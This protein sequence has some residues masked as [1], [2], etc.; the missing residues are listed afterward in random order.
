MF[1]MFTQCKIRWNKRVDPNIDRTPF[2]LEEDQTI[3]ALRTNGKSWPEIASALGGNR[4]S[5]QVKNRFVNVLDPNRRKSAPWSDEEDRI[6]RTAQMQLGNKWSIIAKRLPGRSDNDVK[7]HWYNMKHKQMRNMMKQ[8]NAKR[9][10]ARL[11]QIRRQTQ[12]NSVSSLDCNGGVVTA[13]QSNP[14]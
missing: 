7:N 2:T 4:R 1:L 6:L 11:T 14:V 13:T 8:R 9:R 3:I 12:S 5:D 10:Q